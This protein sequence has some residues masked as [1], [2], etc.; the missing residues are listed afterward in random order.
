MEDMTKTFPKRLHSLMAP[1]A[2]EEE[3]KKYDAPVEAL[4]RLLLSTG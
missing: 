3:T 2:D 4:Q 1:M